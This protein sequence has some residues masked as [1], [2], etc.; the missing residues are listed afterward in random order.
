VLKKIFG[1][2]AADKAGDACDQCCLQVAPLSLVSLVLHCSL[3]AGWV[4]NLG[5]L[6]YPT[7]FIIARIPFCYNFTHL[8][9]GYPCGIIGEDANPNDQFPSPNFDERTP[10]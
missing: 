2:V 9:A 5:V 4:F 1:Q 10:I 8:P 6:L 3:L 7:L